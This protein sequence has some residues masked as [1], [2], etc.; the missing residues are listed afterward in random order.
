MPSVAIVYGTAA[1]STTL[2][3][4]GSAVPSNTDWSIQFIRAANVHASA[5]ANVDVVATD[6]TTVLHLAKNVAVASGKAVNI[7]GPE[8][9][10]LPTGWKVRARASA[11]S[12]IDLMVSG[13]SRSTL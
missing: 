1:L 11:A 7:I 10:K 6:G 9:F 12:S 13:T 8:T 4:V 2:A 5:S 3:D